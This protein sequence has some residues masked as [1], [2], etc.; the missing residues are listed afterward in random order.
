MNE[1]AV[2]SF[3]FLW[4]RQYL[5]LQKC[6]IKKSLDEFQGLIQWVQKLTK[7]QL[8]NVFFLFFPFYFFHPS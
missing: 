7:E 1:K 2:I 4:Q 6:T 5:A 3:Y 8:A